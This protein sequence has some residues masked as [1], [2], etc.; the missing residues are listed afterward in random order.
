MPKTHIVRL[1]LQP[2]LEFSASCIYQARV[3]LSLKNEP[4]INPYISREAKQDITAV[5]LPVRRPTTAHV[6]GVLRRTKSPQ[7]PLQQLWRGQS[8]AAQLQFEGTG[9]R[10]QVQT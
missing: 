4:F 9:R 1:C 3:L 5:S 8:S 7:T 2:R 10:I 6:V